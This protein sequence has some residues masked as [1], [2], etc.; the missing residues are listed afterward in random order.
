M[1]KAGS[2]IRGLLEGSWVVIISG[3]ASR[4]TIVITRIR[5]LLTPPITTHEPSSRVQGVC[6]LLNPR[7]PQKPCALASKP[8]HHEGGCQN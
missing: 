8:Q 7:S 2:S 3:V 4:V 5:G 1:S 6:A